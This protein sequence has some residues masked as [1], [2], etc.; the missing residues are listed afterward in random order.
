MNIKITHHWLQEYLDTKATPYEIQKFLSLCG[1]SVE[2]VEQIGENDW[3]YDIEITSNRVDC[4]S[5]IG[6]AREAATILNR[7][8]LPSRFVAPTEDEVKL[9]PHTI[10]PIQ[11]SDEEKCCSRI[12]AVV[13]DH[14]SVLPSDPIIAKRLEN[15]GIRALNNVVDITN[16]IMMETGHPTHVFDYDRIHSHSLLV[17]HAKK[18]EQITTLDN[19]TYTL[20]SSDI[21]IDDGTG[22]I[23]DFPGIMGTSNSVVTPDTKRIIFF[24]ESNDP[25]SIRRSSMKYGI[26]TKAATLNEKSPDFYLARFA[27]NQG[28]RYF[29]KYAMGKVAGTIIDIY[30][31]EPKP[32]IIH[33]D[34]QFIFKKIGIEIPEKQI[35]DIL[36]QLGFEVKTIKNALQIK[37]PSW[38]LNDVSIPEDIVEEVAR[39]YGYH[40]LPDV[41]SPARYVPQPKSFERLFVYQD[42]VKM[43]LKHVGMNEVLNYS[44]ISEEMIRSVDFDPKDHLCLSNVMSAEIKYLRISLIPSLLK[45]IKQNEGRR[46]TLRFFE[47]AKIYKPE[48]NN[49][50]TETY[51]LS[52]GI[53]TS[54]SD[55][56]GIA[57]ALLRELNIEHAK[58]IPSSNI[59]Y[60]KKMQADIVIK[61]KKIGS[62]GQINTI[63]QAKNNL[64]TPVF[65]MEINFE[66]LISYAS[67]MSRYIPLHPYAVVKLDH[68]FTIDENHPYE[69]IY[70]R[71][72]GRSKLLSKLELIDVFQ[73]KVTL[74]FYF[75]DHTRNL[76]EKE[77]KEELNILLK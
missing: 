60:M 24:I 67:S 61:G 65:C 66:Q 43:F 34:F 55:L 54:F 27:L 3:S 4:A 48:Q 2:K 12:L 69:H 52:L 14:I 8:K 19:K 26:R 40:N 56:K 30:S 18:G 1:P 11:I 62:L 33:T 51:T 64:K 17:R 50:P 32:T 71:M 57:E 53:T 22:K 70:S 20:S 37:V 13:M 39:I 15:A 31:A 6:I 41:L 29:I 38:R 74:R 49:L 72:I 75:S 9:E 63:V 68:T 5:V 16:Y 73:N 25:V 35:V 28:V 59:L 7:F 77:A 46:D 76:S 45:N 44:M 10:L 58:F 23:I 42:S 47:I 21:I 36:T